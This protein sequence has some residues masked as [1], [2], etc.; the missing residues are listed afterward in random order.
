MPERP[1]GAKQGNPFSKPNKGTRF[2]YSDSLI[3]YNYAGGC[4]IRFIAR[5]AIEQAGYQRHAIPL[6]DMSAARITFRSG[7]RAWVPRMF[8]KPEKFADGLPEV[9]RL[10]PEAP[11][12][13]DNASHKALCA[14]YPELAIHPFFGGGQMLALDVKSGQNLWAI[15]NFADGQRIPLSSPDGQAALAAFPI[16]QEI[17][18]FC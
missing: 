17:Q 7:T 1:S 6:Q 2:R 9:F 5:S 8:W 4:G 14:C 10:W 11:R 12:G 18:K 3:R 13:L 16:L 15:D